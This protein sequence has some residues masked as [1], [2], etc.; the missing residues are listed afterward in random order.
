MNIYCP[1]HHAWCVFLNCRRLAKKLWSQKPNRH[2]NADPS[3]TSSIV[4]PTSLP[5]VIAM[6]GFGYLWQLPASLRNSLCES[7]DKWCWRR[8]VHS[9][10]QHQSGP[11][12]AWQVWTASQSSGDKSIIILHLKTQKMNQKRYIQHEKSA[13]NAVEIRQC[14]GP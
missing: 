1:S 9:P 14:I 10:L 8:R 6:A 5:S 12:S 2:H 7:I 3:A 11:H 13:K 4:D